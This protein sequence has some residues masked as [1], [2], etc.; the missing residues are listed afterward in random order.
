MAKQASSIIWFDKEASIWEEALPIGN[1]RLG[2]MIFGKTHEERIGLNEDTVWYGG[3]RDR[4]NPDAAV[5]L[6]DIRRMLREGR[7]KEAHELARFALSGV[8][9]TQRHYTPLGDLLL[10]VQHD[11]PAIQDYR[12]QLDLL[13]GIATVCYRA[14]DVAY[15]REMFAS[16]P[17]QVMVIRFT[18]DRPKRISVIARLMRGRGRYYDELVKADERTIVMRGNCGGAG[19]SDFRAAVR[20]VAIGGEIRIIGE[21]LIVRGADEM[22]L[23]L[24]AGTTFRYEDPEAEALRLLAAAERH[25]YDALKRRHEADFR[26]LSERSALALA[27]DPEAEAL[28]TDARLERMKRGA[29]DHGL[30]ALY[31]QFGRYLLISSSRPGSLPANL[32]GIWNER[33]LPPWD[34]KYTININT[35]MNYWP[36]ELCNLSECHEPLFDL[37]ERMREPGRHTARVMYGARG[38]TAHHNTDI[39]ADTAPQDIYLPASYWPMGAAWLC[40][41]LWEHYEFTLD[42]EFLLRAY[43][44]MEEAALFFVD[45]LEETEDGKLVTNPSVSPENTYILPN[46]EKGQLC[47][48]AAM[49]SQILHELF[50]ACLAAYDIVDGEHELRSTFEEERAF[51]LFPLHVIAKG[52][53]GQPLESIWTDVTTGHTVTIV[54]EQLLEPAMKRPLTAE[55]LS[56]QWGRLGGTIFQLDK[57]DFYLA[58][59]VIVPVSELN[60]MRREAVDQLVQLRMQPVRYTKRSIKVDSI[61]PLKVAGARPSERPAEASELIALCRS[62]DQIIAACEADADWIYADFEFTNDY[63]RAVELAR[64]YGK[65]IALATPRIHMPGENGILGGIVKAG[66]DAVL[67]RNLGALQYYAESRPAGIEL[68]GDFSLNIANHLAAELFLSRGLQRI[69]PSYDLNIQQMIDLLERAPVDRIEIVIQQHLPMFHTEHCV[70]CTFLS[71]G[72]DFTNCGRPCESHRVSLQDRI[73]MLHPVRVDTGCRNTVYNAIEQSGAEYLPNFLELGVRSYRVEFLE[74]DGAKV[75]E[76]LRLY[77]EALQGKRTGTSVWRTLKATNQLGVTRGQLVKK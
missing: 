48:G 21:H 77:R 7:L 38:F 42:R 28:P 34:S 69:T 8:P 26:S 49:D 61:Q 5:Y 4:N 30:I 70:Y 2:G 10:E 25:G 3:P 31:Y 64:R 59:D 65:P 45:Y 72:T 14:G 53:A 40:L 17:D 43:P 24:A 35:Q 56:E 46:G 32:Q 29:H 50:S 68:R 13:S 62:T 58:G 73:G 37:I 33:M 11:S 51:R 18:A 12:R 6:P 44:I 57:L 19:G 39:W 20:A 55:Y 76:V 63:P 52:K 27:T 22:T 9:E 74:E 1:G 67:V 54:S 15:T 16:Y 60:R 71:E 75:Q 41:H 66:P 36:A 47:I 23:L